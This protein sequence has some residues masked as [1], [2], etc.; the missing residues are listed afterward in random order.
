MTD[1]E[2]WTV[3]DHP[4]DYPRNFVARKFINDKPT[5]NIIQGL[6]L[7]EV[8]KKILDINPN[9]TCF[10]RQPNDDPIILETWL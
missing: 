1:I 3:Y 5:N 2:I 10:T 6:S 7:D 9:L 8:R 4:R